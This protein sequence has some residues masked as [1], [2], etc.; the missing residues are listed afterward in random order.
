MSLATDVIDAMIEDTASGVTAA[1]NAF[2]EEHPAM[3]GEWSKWGLEVGVG[4]RLQI[5]R[6][7]RQQ[8]ATVEMQEMEALQAT[9]RS[10]PE[11]HTS[12]S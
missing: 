8:V 5:L 12:A 3:A 11:R 7:V 1:Q 4:I 2:Y 10:A 9:Q 6:E